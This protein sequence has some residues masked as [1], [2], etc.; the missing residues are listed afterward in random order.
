MDFEALAQKA[1]KRIRQKM[2]VVKQDCDSFDIMPL[3]DAETA[4]KKVVLS[5]KI[6]RFEVHPKFWT[7]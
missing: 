2:A 1:E 4:G 6:D 3:D 5:T 7:D